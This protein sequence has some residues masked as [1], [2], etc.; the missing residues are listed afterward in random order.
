MTERVRKTHSDHHPSYV[1]VE[2]RVIIT[3]IYFPAAKKR[4][5]YVKTLVFEGLTDIAPRKYDTTDHETLD[6]AREE[7]ASRIREDGTVILPSTPETRFR[8]GA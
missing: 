3:D 4:M 1:G 7:F 6:E 2:R 5:Y 8:Y